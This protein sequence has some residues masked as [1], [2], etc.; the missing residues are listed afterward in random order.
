[1][2]MRAAVLVAISLLMSVSARATDKVDT[3]R[4]SIQIPPQNLRVALQT[5]G[6]VEGLYMVFL[7]ED[8]QNWNTEGVSGSLT[9]AEALEQL[10]RGTDLTYR[11]LEAHT[12][13]ILPA[14]KSDLAS[15]D[16][17]LRVGQV[18]ITAPAEAQQ[19]EY[20]RLLA[21]MSKEEY[22]H[23]AKTLPF[24]D[25]GIVTFPGGQ[26]P[27]QRLP[28]GEYIQSAGVAGL[29]LWRVLY[30]TPNEAASELQV[31]NSNS[32]PVF[33]EID[34]I[35]GA[36]GKG[37]YAAIA[38]GETAVWNWAPVHCQA[39]PSWAPYYLYLLAP[40]DCFEYEI[41]PGKAHVRLLKQWE[42]G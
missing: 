6:E 14:S 17:G 34:F 1:M 9:R 28:L 32:F 31:H 20:F 26:G 29:V 12:V 23:V 40:W 16:P 21:A 19:V 41:E 24:V 8:V 38:P 7:S 4:K 36:L 3:T 15:A 11:F 42:P 33:V 18:T 25:T 35:P 2:L 37:A 27:E 22:R 10:L 5:L 39:R 30:L 13:M